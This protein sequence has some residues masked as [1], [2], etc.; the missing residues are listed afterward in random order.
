MANEDIGYG[1]TVTI[2]GIAVTLVNSLK[3]PAKSAEVIDVTTMSSASSTKEKIG[4]LINWEAGSVEFNWD[5]RLA[6]HGNFFAMV[7]TTVAITC[8]LP[9]A[10]SWGFNAVISKFAP[11]DLT[12][13]GKMTGSIEFDP[14]GVVTI[15]P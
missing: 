7:S 13:D 4:G 11:G 12:P 14:A 3:L 2:G 9:G 10:Q 6:G 1:T 8:V 15:T 5:P